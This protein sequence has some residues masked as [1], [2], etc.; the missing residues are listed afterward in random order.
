MLAIT[1]ESSV[2]LL[3]FQSVNQ[4]A[5]G[6][7][8]IAAG[9][10]GLGWLY[11]SRFQSQKATQKLCADDGKLEQCAVGRRGLKIGLINR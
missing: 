6:K 9:H 3:G 10:T 5:V 11:R 2:T 7:R 1:A 8:I 4:I